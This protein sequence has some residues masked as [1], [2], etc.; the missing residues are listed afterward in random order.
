M[1]NF[2]HTPFHTPESLYVLNEDLLAAEDLTGLSLIM[3]FTGFSDAGHV[4][5]QINGEL[6]DHLAHEP[7]AVF[8]IDQLIDYRSRRP[9]ITFSEDHLSDYRPPSLVLHRMVDA[10][11]TPFLYLYGTEPDLQWERF[12]KAILGLVDRLDVN[13]VA[14]V[15]SVPMPVPHTRPI[16]ATVHGN[17]PELIEGISA[18]KATMEV[19]AAIGHVIEFKLTDAGRNVVGYAIHVPHYLSDAEYPPA[20]VAGLEYLGAAASLMLPSERLREAGRAV[21][22]QITEQVEA[23]SDVAGVVTKLERQY[24][25]HSE[26]TARRSLLAGENDELPDADELGAAVEAYLASRDGGATAEPD[27]G[28]S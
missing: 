20:A 25:E 1:N 23:S 22:R 15:H 26:G 5:T 28:I 4:V 19:P 12:S 13:L 3:A 7:L 2:E 11:G 6:A 21:E 8:D 24:D 16:G 17:R 14:W 9:R 10:L 27:G 18:W